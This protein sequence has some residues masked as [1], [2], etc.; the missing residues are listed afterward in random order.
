MNTTVE[1]PARRYWVDTGVDAV[2]GELVTFRAS[3]RW[4]DWFIDC[5]PEG[6]ERRYLSPIA[7]LRR[8][9]SAR[10]FCLCVALDKDMATARPVGAAAHVVFPR[11]GRIYAFANDAPFAYL[12]N[13]RSVT[14]Q[15]EH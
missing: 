3:G 7:F 4:R 8:V 9:P 14:L 10:W 11:A 12:N 6:Y 2:P 13:A 5:G 15:L 1:V